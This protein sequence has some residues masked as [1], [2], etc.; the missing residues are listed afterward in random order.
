LHLLEQNK[1]L[2]WYL[3]VI[4]PP[5]ATDITHHP[6]VYLSPSAATKLQEEPTWIW[7]ICEFRSKCRLP[8]KRHEIS[9][10]FNGSL[11]GSDGYSIEPC[12]FRWP[13]AAV[14]DGTRM[15]NFPGG[16]RTYAHTLRLC[17]L[18]HHGAIEIGFMIIIYYYHLAKNNPNQMWGGACL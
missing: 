8:R 10:W 15:A 18:G 12:W 7:K 17:I 6:I 9:P 1:D 4:W 5:S 16:F 13:W 14:K 2:I 3:G 11:I